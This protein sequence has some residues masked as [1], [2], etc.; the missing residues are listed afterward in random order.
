LTVEN[1]GNSP[2]QNLVL[3]DKVPDSFE[4]GEYSLE[5]AVT[6]EVGAD[7]LKWTIEKLEEGEKLEITYKIKGSGDYKPSEAQLAL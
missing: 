1:I 5:P 6:D 3:L 7:T 2:L 4:Y